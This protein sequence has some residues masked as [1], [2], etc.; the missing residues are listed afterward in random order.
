[1]R[2]LR[3]DVLYALRQMRL[4]PIFTLTAML[5]L[6]LGIGATTAIFSLIHSVMLK[7][8][9]VADPAS[10]YR[11]GDNNDCCVQGG[12]QD[13]WGLFPYHLYLRFIAAAPEFEQLAA[14]QGGSSEF[15]ARQSE[16]NQP[17]RPM[18]GEYVS[19]NY[20]ST[21]GIQAYAGRTITPADDQQSSAPAAISATA[22]GSRNTRPTPKSLAPRSCSMAIHSRS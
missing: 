16:T 12:P 13:N 22:C 6:A 7:S 11:V 9:P 1:M 8:L 15:S 21:F 10:L 20:F 5:T 17:A 19:G 18:R 2:T 4:S 14:F 3:R